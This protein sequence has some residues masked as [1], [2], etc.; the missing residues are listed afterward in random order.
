MLND[1]K[2]REE[3]IEK[4]NKIEETNISMAVL[5]PKISI[6]I[7]SMNRLSIPNKREKLDKQDKKDFTTVYKRLS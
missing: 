2:G 4:Q 1:Q 7:L 6:D 5:N 3:E